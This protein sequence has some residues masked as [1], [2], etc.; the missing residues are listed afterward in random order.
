MIIK[1]NHLGF[2]LIEI[3]MVILLLG[4]L[5][6][7]ATSQFINF[8]DDAH[9][10]MTSEKLAALKIAIVG[11]A[12][13]ISAGKYTNLGYEAHCKGVPVSL[14]DL[15]T[16][17]GAGTCS[18]DYDPFTKRGWRGPYVSNTDTNYNNDSWGTAL[19]Y[20]SGGRTITSCGPNATCTD[21]DDI[22][23]SF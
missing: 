16:Q 8:S 14:T 21:G 4:I 2:T 17:P 15:I 10:T 11:D 7:A 3:L 5:G 9:A 18:V 1:S 22:Q 6:A 20:S 12:R 19:V 13:S 23:I